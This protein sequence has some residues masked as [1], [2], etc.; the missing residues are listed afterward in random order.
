MVSFERKRLK[1]LM[2]FIAEPTFELLLIVVCPFPLAETKFANQK[3]NR[4]G[5]FLEVYQSAMC[6]IAV[7]IYTG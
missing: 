4:Q 5:I 2:T 6:L 1:N 3:E 7:A